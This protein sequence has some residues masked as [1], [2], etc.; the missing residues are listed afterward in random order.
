MRDKRKRPARER[1]LETSVGNELGRAFRGL[2]R[3]VSAALRPH[4]L[5]AVQGNILLTLWARGPLTIGELQKE[6]A[7]SSAAL[8]GAIDRM[9]RSELLRRV[10]VESDRRSFRVEPAPWPA[11]RR[12]AVIEALVQAEDEFLAALGEGDRD[13]LLRLLRKV[14]GSRESN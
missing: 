13:R 5:S 2:N 3:A 6:M 12:R 1:R 9:E 11:A 14:A 7:F 4:G 10:P 8:S